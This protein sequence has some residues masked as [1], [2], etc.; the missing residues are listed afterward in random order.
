MT[1]GWLLKT[2]HFESMTSKDFLAFLNSRSSL[3]AE[4]VA[5]LRKA[6]DSRGQPR[7]PASITRLLVRRGHLTQQ[8]ASRILSEFEA[9][10]DELLPRP[11]TED[12]D[13]A[14]QEGIGFAVLD[15]EPAPRPS[16][17]P[18]NSSS[19]TAA[20]NKK[21][22]GSSSSALREAWRITDAEPA[23]DNP[24]AP[25][26]ELWGELDKLDH[27][28]I[29][30]AG[31][32][33]TIRRPRRKRFF[34]R[35]TLSELK[36]WDSPLMLAGGGILLLLIVV[37]G[38]LWW[39]LNRQDA[40]ELLR[41]AE[42]DFRNESYSQAIAKYSTFIDEFPDH[43]Q[44]SAAKVNR[45]MARLRHASSG[46]S[47]FTLALS[48][49]KQVLQEISSEQEFHLA[50]GELAAM[51]PAI[52]EGISEQAQQLALSLDANEDPSASRET[53]QRAS[54]LISETRSA[55]ELVGRYVRA[56]LRPSERMAE[57][58]SVL[59][60]VSRIVKRQNE[61]QVSIDA[62]RA[63]VE[64]NSPQTAFET[65]RELVRNFPELAENPALQDAVHSAAEQLRDDVESSTA[66]N[67]IV[68][69]DQEPET[70]IR[71]SWIP[72]AR[73]GSTS[74]L[75]IEGS[76]A[77][78]ANGA[79]F[80]VSTEDGSV[81]WR[82]HVG[83]SW[84]HM[85]AAIPSANGES[86][87]LSDVNRWEIISV[88]ADSGRLN[89]RLQLGERFLPPVV[90]QGAVSVSTRSGKVYFIDPLDGKII[91]I[92]NIPQQLEV[93][94]LWED[95]TPHLYQLA[96]HSNLYAIN[97]ANGEC[98]E[99]VYL[100]HDPASVIVPPVRIL[101][102]IIVAENH[103]HQ[104]SRLRVMLADEGGATLRE[105][106]TL[107]IDGLVITPPVALGR[108]MYL[109]TDNGTIY[110]FE[111]IKNGEKGISEVLKRQSQDDRSLVRYLYAR[112]NQLWVASDR[113]A[114]YNVQ[115]SRGRID[116]N[117]MNSE[118][119]PVLQPPVIKQQQAF[120]TQQ[121]S[122][123]AG[124][125][126]SA[127]DLQGAQG[128]AWQT[129]LAAPLAGGLIAVDDST[130]LIV[131][132]AGAAYRISLTSASPSQMAVE[133][134]ARVPGVAAPVYFSDYA[135][136]I[137]GSQI[138]TGAVDD[139]RVLLVTA[140]D[141]D[142]SHWSTNVVELPVLEQLAFG[143]MAIGDQ[144]LLADTAGRVSLYGL[145]ENSK[146][147]L[148]FEPPLSPG[149][150][151]AW[152]SPAYSPQSPGVIFLADGDLSIYRLG[153]SNE[154]IPH[155]TQQGEIDL[156]EPVQRRLALA[157]D[158]LY[159]VDQRN[160]VLSFSVNDLL[161]GESWELLA[162]P[163]YGPRQVGE[164]V[165]LATDA[166]ELFCF[167]ANGGLAWKQ[168]MHYGPLAGD[169]LPLGESL[170][171][172]SASGVVWRVGKETGEELGHVGLDEPLRTGPAGFHLDRVLV[173][174]ADDTM[175]LISVP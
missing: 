15:D 33:G 111:V 146:E 134:M 2:K 162:P 123:G 170:L 149:K 41:Q 3:P 151:F 96:D 83:S 81:R 119:R 115:A 68:P 105:V 132:A 79:V 131:T 46:T 93:P 20:A 19:D 55:L 63:A 143:P 126:V 17:S 101:R 66:N 71:A 121:A 88:Q 163:V 109:A 139:P 7:S 97:R 6:T 35:R 67:G 38:V 173:G 40:D 154:P 90:A 157:G 116:L 62:I 23:E 5:Q 4:L 103:R 168:K 77:V 25:S 144:L 69:L 125:S 174:G 148:P 73:T 156:V 14:A 70:S 129:T 130:W 53:T 127:L 150:R 28:D 108:R 106:Q 166:D 31:Q 60:S 52:A 91:R 94:P 78:I 45:G 175:H 118:G 89:W 110:V 102:N 145:G 57:V 86:Y 152:Q 58:E 112:S 65:K 64:A 27:A 80:G 18:P 85:P 84:D 13:T 72:F 36:R 48:T 50:R 153:V 140:N 161:A 87:I 44:F 76:L 113:F 26:A 141:G 159:A 167:D 99:V 82:R 1:Y 128:Q 22:R 42:E 165:L 100:G 104:S 98:D 21:K 30:T 160:W 138:F 137:N 155:L 136:A 12:A 74:P 107:P 120:L 29:S 8:A 133:P 92:T 95:Q 51:L 172:S 54:A 24:S 59:A 142:S 37:G 171:L 169:P 32:S 61:L 114:S 164:L 117:W 43:A 75:G 39:T 124:I 47:D 158:T 56:E 122:E 34:Q 16:S 147:I 10:D 49:A 9:D 135:G 11:R